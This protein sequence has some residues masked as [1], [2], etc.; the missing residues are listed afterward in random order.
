MSHNVE[1]WLAWTAPERSGRMLL[2]CVLLM[3]SYCA[4]AGLLD[5]E[6]SF[7]E[8]EV[9]A[10][11]VRK[12]PVEKRYGGLMSVRMEN[13]P[14]IRIGTPEQRVT[15]TGQ[16]TISSPLAR[17]PVPVDVVATAGIRYDDAAKAFFLEQPSAESVSSP[18]L[19]RDAEPLARQGVAALLKHY[20]Q[21][22]PVYVL[23]EDGSMKEK[24]ARWLLKS[25]R[26]E[27]G[28]V[29]ATLSPF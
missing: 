28:K 4:H 23:R 26:I 11:L 13:A 2:Y 8:A 20:F 17:Q 12:G 27:P 29:V 21:D 25:V 10:A 3:L 16:V 9:Q 18:Q 5:Q 14:T 15:I 1:G 7:D 24:A 6:L 22:R 19:S